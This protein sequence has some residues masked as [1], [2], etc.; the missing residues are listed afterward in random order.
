MDALR[1]MLGT[2]TS[3]V[4]TFDER[5]VAGSH[6][7]AGRR[8]YTA[9]AYDIT[10]TDTYGTT[11]APGALQAAEGGVPLLL[12]HDRASFPVGKIV[13]WD[14]TERGPEARFVFADTEQAR[15][16]EALVAGGFLRGVSVGFIPSDGFVREDGVVV[17]TDAEVVELSLTP[18]PSSRGALVDLQRSIADLVGSDGSP[19]DETPAAAVEPANPSCDETEDR[20]LT[21]EEAIEQVAEARDEYEAKMQAIAAELDAEAQ[22]AAT[23][24]AER[25]RTLRTLS[26]IRRTA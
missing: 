25:A 17:F 20:D 24:A 26:R 19:S 1:D 6:D 3:R 8:V 5:A 22:Q 15:T 9:L 13:G 2:V 23:V 18:T 12:F 16:A 7:D 10:T 11:M 14:H 4:A 21:V